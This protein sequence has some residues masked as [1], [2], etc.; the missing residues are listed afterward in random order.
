L[1]PGTDYRPIT[2]QEIEEISVY[3]IAIESW[4]AMRKVAPTDFPGAFEFAA[5]SI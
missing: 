2:Q 4:S 1:R 3:R 5:G